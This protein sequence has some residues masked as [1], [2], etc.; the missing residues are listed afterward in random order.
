MRVF[1]Y[2][3]TPEEIDR[4]LHLRSRNGEPRSFEIIDREPAPEVM[5]QPP[6]PRAT[7]R[8]GQGQELLDMLEEA[9]AHHPDADDL[10]ILR[11]QLQRYLSGT[12]VNG[13]KPRQNGRSGIDLRP[14]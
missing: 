13:S 5:H 4:F 1:E 7:D 14:A 2:E 6:Q 12:R 11:Q 3:G 9:Q 8:H 10:E